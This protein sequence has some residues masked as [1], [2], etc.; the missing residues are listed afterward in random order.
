MQNA[1]FARKRDISAQKCL[2]KVK[3][4]T[5]KEDSTKSAL[6]NKSKS[7]KSKDAKFKKKKSNCKIKF[8]DTQDEVSADSEISSHEEWLLCRTPQKRKADA[9]LV[10]LSINNFSCKIE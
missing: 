3:G 5:S 2:E 7:K 9:I 6:Q 1:I 8:V 4:A 10:S